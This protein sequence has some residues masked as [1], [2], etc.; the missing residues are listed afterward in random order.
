[1]KRIVKWLIKKYLLHDQVN[2]LVKELTKEYL[3]LYHLSRNPVRKKKE[4]VADDN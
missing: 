4:G 2:D 1:M 3:P